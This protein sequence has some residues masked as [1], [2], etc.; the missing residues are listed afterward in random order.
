MARVMP[1]QVVQ[2]I[3]S[4]YPH[5]RNNSP[6]HQLIGNSAKLQGVLNLLRK[7]PDELI[8][9]PSADYAEV[10]LA[11]RTIDDTLAYWRSNISAVGHIAPVGAFDVMTVI[12]RALA[13]CS[14]EYPPSTTTE[15]MFIKDDE[16]RESIRQDI[17]NASRALIDNEW[18]AATVLAGAA[19]EA[20]LHWRLK[21]PTPGPAA[22]QSAVRSLTGTKK[23][24]FSDIDRWDLDQFIEVAVQLRL[25]EPDT[26]TAAKLAK[27]FRNLIHPGRAAR[28]AQSCDRATAYSAIG[29]LEHVI[30][31][32]S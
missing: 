4:L 10:I 22:V 25:I 3:D 2:T 7:V 28:L 29:A 5:A 6:G 19:I 31:D 14:D 15:L 12:R 1:S 13:K 11:Q 24:P 17:G 23:M 32:L 20:L 8:A 18:K 26:S 27:N 9:L 21:D 16:L 30:R